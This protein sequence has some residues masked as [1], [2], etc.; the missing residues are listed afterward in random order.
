MQYYP[1]SLVQFNKGR[2]GEYLIYKY[3]KGHEINGAM[4]LFNVYVPKEN[5]ETSEIDVIMIH[6]KGIFVFES[7][8]YS[9]WIFGSET[10]RMWTQTLPKGRKRSHKESFYNPIIQNV[11]M[12]VIFK[13]VEV[14]ISS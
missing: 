12:F 13:K 2:Y 7:K 5:G 9:G 8:N 6:H 3:L 10:Q 14:L 4:F 1:Q 11:G